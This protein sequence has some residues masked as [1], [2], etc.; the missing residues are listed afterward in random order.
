MKQGIA[1]V[2]TSSLLVACGGGSENN[3]SPTDNDLSDGGVSFNETHQ[4]CKSKKG[5][6]G[7]IVLTPSQGVDASA[8]W[9]LI[10][11]LT[12]AA[13]DVDL[14]SIPEEKQFIAS[15]ALTG[16]LAPSLTDAFSSLN[17]IYACSNALY[18]ENQCNWELDY[19]ENGGFKVETT[20]GS[21]NQYTATVSTRD[22]A[23]S[24]LQK[25]LE[26]SGVIGDLGN[27]TFELFENGVSV[28]K[29]E[30][31]RT[32]QG[33]ETV[34]WTSSKTNWVATESSSCTG[35]LEYE[36]IKD[37]STISIDAQWDFNGAKTTGTLDYVN[38]GENGTSSIT[39]DW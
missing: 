36:D 30:A 6:D 28:G 35:S 20:F 8:E 19:A 26:L 21:D 7:E 4:V 34:R 13:S 31:T 5:N 3:D 22:D 9:L 14:D 27:I 39:I 24:S 33:I 29:R 2:L 32:A 37:D 25:S 18:A 11:S 17:G 12:A 16:F 10:E 23:G 15:F 38:V 1:I